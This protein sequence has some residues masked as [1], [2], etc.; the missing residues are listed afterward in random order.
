[1][2]LLIEM[3]DNY[4]NGVENADE[5]EVLLQ[6]QFGFITL[7]VFDRWILYSGL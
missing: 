7:I 3:V 1:V 4:I 5:D 6:T 2:A